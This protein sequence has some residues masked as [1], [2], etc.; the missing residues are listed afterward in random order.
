MDEREERLRRLKRLKRKRTVTVV[1]LCVLLAGLGGGYFLLRQHNER[2]ESEKAEKEAQKQAVS[3]TVEITT[4]Q[5]TEVAEIAFSN[6]E[7]SYPD[8]TQAA[9]NNRFNTLSGH[10]CT[11]NPM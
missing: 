8:G 10:K 1:V 9:Q 6:D 4:F 3:E 2:K 7:A 5:M 11:K